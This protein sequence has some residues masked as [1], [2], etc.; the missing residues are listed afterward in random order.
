M[1]AGAA[2]VRL[3]SHR[4]L[5]DYQFKV[6]CN[7]LR[8]FGSWTEKIILRETLFRKFNKAIRNNEIF[9]EEV[10]LE[11]LNI[12]NGDVHRVLIH[13]ADKAQMELIVEKG[14]TK[15]VRNIAKQEL[16]SRKFK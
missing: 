1:M 8:F 5:S 13:Y 15:A 16:R 2:I 4:E 12:G 6:V 11:F 10:F 14:S 7:A 3:L 9:K